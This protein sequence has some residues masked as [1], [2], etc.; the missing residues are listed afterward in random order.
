MRET[1]VAKDKRVKSKVGFGPH[2]PGLYQGRQGQKRLVASPRRRG[3]FG[4]MMPTRCHIKNASAL[5]V[6]FVGYYMISD[7]L[8]IVTR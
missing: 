1:G 2:F 4:T 6:H 3:L 7:A 8:M 5:L